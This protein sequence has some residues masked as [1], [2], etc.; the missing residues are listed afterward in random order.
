MGV[1]IDAG[2]GITRLSGINA[3]INGVSGTTLGGLNP[4]TADT[5]L[6]ASATDGVVGE[7]SNVSDGGLIF[8]EGGEGSFT[9][10][11][12]GGGVVLSNFTVSAVPEPSSIVCLAGIGLGLFVRRRR[13][14]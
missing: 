2:G 4:L 6:I 10:N 11:Y 14:V 3:G 5:F 1:G 7:F 8:T 13:R 9:V 12:T